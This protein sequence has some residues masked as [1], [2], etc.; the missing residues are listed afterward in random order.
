MYVFMYILYNNTRVGEDTTA[1]FTLITV[2]YSVLILLVP[3]YGVCHAQ[4]VY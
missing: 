4:A 2:Q 3:D 1:G